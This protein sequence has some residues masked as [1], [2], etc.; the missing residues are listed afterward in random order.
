MPVSL[1]P[2]RSPRPPSW[3]FD[4][5]L[6]R[7]TLCIEEE[8]IVGRDNTF[9]NGGV[10]LQLPESSMRAQRRGAREGT[11]IS[12]R[13]PGD[14]CTTRAAFAATITPAA[15]S[16][17][18]IGT[19]KRASRSNKRNWTCS[20]IAVT[21]EE[22]AQGIVPLTPGPP[23]PKR[24]TDVLR[25]PDNSE[26]TDM[27]EDR[28]FIPARTGRPSPIFPQL[29]SRFAIR[30]CPREKSGFPTSNARRDCIP[31]QSELGQLNSYR[32]E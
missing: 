8:R 24:T 9:A 30:G 3:L 25:K 19:K 15:R 13:P 6:L 28:T 21:P 14:F 16:P 2:R 18:R 11:R 17:P 4:A 7:E 22:A 1:G 23:Q 31:L 10:K 5:E 29:G 32:L 27:R 26:A 12:G 20:C